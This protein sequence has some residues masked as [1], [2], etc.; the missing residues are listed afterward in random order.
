[1]GMEKR[2][3]FILL[4]ILFCFVFLMTGCEKPSEDTPVQGFTDWIPYG[5]DKDGSTWFYN[6]NLNVIKDGDSYFVQTWAKR[7]LS[8]KG[9]EKAIQEARDQG[10]YVDGYDK[11]SED[12]M[13]NEVDCGKQR[14]RMIFVTRYDSSGKILLSEDRR[15][16]EWQPVVP[17][18]HGGILYRRVCPEQ[19]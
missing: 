13:L 3:T 1:M 2:Y 16:G 12:K 9:K 4:L 15:Q 5:K 18:S 7:V 17:K 6:R 14:L 10:K 11:L 19:K 8:D